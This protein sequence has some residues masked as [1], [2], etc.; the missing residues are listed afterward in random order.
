[1]ARDHDYPAGNFRFHLNFREDRLSG[2]AGA[3]QSLCG[4]AFAECSGL[5]A[6]HEPKLIREGGL[7]YGAH[8]RAGTTTF[9]T[10]ILRRGI[11]PNTDLWKWFEQSTVRGSYAYRLDV[12]IEHLD[13]DGSVVRTWKLERALPVKFKSGDLN[14]RG[15]EVAVEELHLVHEGLTLKD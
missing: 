6:T 1:M 14:A 8:Q 13:V 9:A 3:D 10:V 2:G 4:G 7:N 5:E 15:G 11:T 12:E